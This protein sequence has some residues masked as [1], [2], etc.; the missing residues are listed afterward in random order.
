VEGDAEGLR[1]FRIP[2]PAEPDDAPSPR[3]SDS[4]STSGTPRHSSKHAAAQQPQQP[5]PLSQLG[6]QM[7]PVVIPNAM[8]HVGSSGRMA[9]GSI[10]GSN[11]AA[12]RQQQQ[13]QSAAGGGSSGSSG[14]SSG[15]AGLAGPG[16]KKPAKSDALAAPGATKQQQQQQPAPPPA[17]AVN[18]A[19]PNSVP[20]AAAA[21]AG[22]VNGGSGS[23]GASDRCSSPGLVVGGLDA[24]VAARLA[25]GGGPLPAFLQTPVRRDGQEDLP[26]QSW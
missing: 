11:A 12:A 20:A 26:T 8:R 21:A 17:A 10:T 1:F 4:S 14:G 19:A 13:Q 15:V 9:A 18:G 23:S 25:A 3:H 5:P 16:L 2:A 7:L 24:D 22:A 6:Q